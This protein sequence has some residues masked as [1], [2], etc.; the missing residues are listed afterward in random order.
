ML[1]GHSVFIFVRKL[2][3]PYQTVEKYF[4]TKGFILDIGCGHGTLAHH[5]AFTQK[6][7]EVLGIDPSSIKIR[8]AN[9][10]YRGLKNLKFRQAY[11]KSIN[12]KWQAISLI[13]VLYLFPD[14]DKLSILKLSRDRLKKG[15]ILIINETERSWFL[16]LEEF[17]MV[18]FL[19][20]TYTDYQNIE[21]PPKKKILSLLR[22]VGFK[23]IRTKTINGLLPYKHILYLAQN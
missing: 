21:I 4:P 13:S 18:K 20:L 17:L 23:H 1:L 12:G 6:D 9:K 3:F 14:D 8:E 19:K 7:R 10:I 16:K 22:K 2:I 11:L 5:L 15:G